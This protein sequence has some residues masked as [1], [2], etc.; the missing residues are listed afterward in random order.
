MK[1]MFGLVGILIALAIVGMLVKTQ[2]RST[3][4]TVAP[5][6]QAA[7]VSITS[8]EGAT[9]AQQGQQIQQQVKEQLNAAMQAAPRPDA[10][11]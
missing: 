6:A 3:T 10:D 2:L 11:K 8:T 1:A 4:A 7:G 9:P 5:A